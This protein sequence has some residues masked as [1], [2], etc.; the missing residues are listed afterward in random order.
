MSEFIEF[1]SMAAADRIR[2][3]YEEHLCPIDDDKRKKTVA[4]TSDTPEALLQRIEAEATE[5]RAEGNQRSNTAEL[6]DRERDKIGDLDGFDRTTTTM[7]WASAKGVFSREGL[8]DQFRDAIGYLTDYDDP[9]EGAE[10]YVREYQSGGQGG[11]SRDV[12]EEDITARQRDANA[13]SREQAEGCDHARDVCRHGDPQACEFLTDACGFGEDEVDE[14]LGS[15]DDPAEAEPDE[16]EG[17]AAGALSR[18]WSG[19][20]GAIAELGEA[21]DQ[22]RESWENATAAA[23]AINGIR[24]QHG[25]EPLHYDALEVANAD[26]LDLV[27]HAAADCEECHA[28]HS[29]HDHAVTEDDRE[30]LGE[31]VENGAA[32]TPVGT[33]ENTDAAIAEQGDRPTDAELAERAPERPD[34]AGMDTDP[35]GPAAPIDSTP[36]RSPDTVPDAPR[37]EMLRDTALAPSDFNEY[38]GRSRPEGQRAQERHRERLDAVAAADATADGDTPDGLEQFAAETQGTLGTGVDAEQAAEEKQVTLGGADATE[39]NRALPSTWRREGSAWVAGPLRIQIDSSGS[40]WAVRLYGPDHRFDV[41]TGLR[42]PEQA[43]A[44]AEGFA[45]RV[46][47]D[48]VSFHSNDSTV[49]EAAAAAKADA[50]PDSGGL[51]E[52][53]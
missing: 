2:E 40:R 35:K 4:F 42:S 6:T 3:Q 17:K 29:D 49:P 46:A 16:I 39:S 53:A 44:I 5:D 38:I 22:V 37:S 9:A 32:S 25:Q 12:G 34:P 21:L 26:L 24:S 8:G 23:E 28:D 14:I 36:N 1:G 43:E 47:P 27:R 18:S 52:F 20:R 7:S 10:Q 30:T 13:A 31:Y 45:E 11:G 50:A 51:N 41:A 33:S 15:E 48:A 19:Y